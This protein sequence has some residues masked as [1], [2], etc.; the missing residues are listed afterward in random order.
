M[1][2]R[3]QPFNARALQQMGVPPLQSGLDGRGVVIGFVDYGFDILHPCLRNPATGGTRFLALW[4]QNTGRE[5]NAGAIDRLIAKAQQTGSRL[6]ADAAYDP[7]ANSFERH[8]VRAGAHGTLI[9]SIAAGSAVAGFRGI[10]PA[11]G[12][13]GVQLGLL[14]HHWKEED[15]A[16][17][18]TWAGWRPEAQPIWNGWRSYDAAPQIVSAL[19]YVYERASRMRAAALAVNLSIG[20]YAGA[21]DGRSAVEQ[22]I[23]DLVERG[24]RGDGPP[25]AVV[26]GAGNAGVEEGHCSGDAEPGRPLSFAWRM[27]RDDLTQNK[28]EIWYRLAAPL[29]IS[30][31]G[32]VES[33][34]AA[35]VPVIPGRTH[36]IAADGVRIGIA[37][38]VPQARAPLSR[39]RIL[40]HPPYIP[41]HLWPAGRGE[42][43]F[44]IRCAAAPD[45][46][47][48]PVHA[49]IERDDGLSSRST[50]HPSHAASTL[51]G[52]ATARGAIV[53]AGHDHH[54]HGET[55]A[56]F[57]FSS[58]GPAP[59]SWGRAT[60]A[61]LV[62][63]PGHRIWGARS[64]TQGFVETSGTSAAAALTSGAVALLMQR[65]AGSRSFEP[66]RLAALPAGRRPYW[67][68]RFG[69]GAVDIAY[70][71]EEMAA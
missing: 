44:E 49:W 40:V 13:I 43:S 30:I 59:W 37:D 4:D 28:L 65:L 27:N 3:A 48:A 16:G 33:S 50:L 25:C 63:A 14:D 19:E 70:S 46:G 24:V 47:R 64:K 29:E 71:L 67:S 54:R 22:K 10:A 68:P 7:H 56:V 1:A 2:N 66:Q 55:A 69:H 31:S 62:S 23:T 34:G 53:V 58:L 8:G 52:I 15:A 26:V 42:L 6:A 12:L 45:G 20:A 9:A 39:V 18:P 61:P 35:A 5:F 17:V 60:P 32:P 21:H 36:V 51:S 11:A 57:P 38:H 41:E